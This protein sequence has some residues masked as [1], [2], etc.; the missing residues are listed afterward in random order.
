MTDGLH[1]AEVSAQGQP[2]C[3]P[4]HS[5]ELAPGRVSHT[6]EQQARTEQNIESTNSIICRKKVPLDS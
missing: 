4:P 2:V 3:R 1:E 6:E 5:G